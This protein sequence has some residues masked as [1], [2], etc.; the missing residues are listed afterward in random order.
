MRTKLVVALLIVL[1]AATGNLQRPPQTEQIKLFI[2]H[3]VKQRQW[4]IYASESQWKS[5]VNSSGAPTVASLEFEA[6]H[7]NAVDLTHQDEAGDWIVYDQYELGRTGELQQDQREIRILPGDR[8]VKEVYL[9]RD[10]IAHKQN[11]NTQSLSTGQKLTNVEDWLP[12]VPV[13]SRLKDFPFA[14]LIG[15]DRSRI[16]AKGKI[17]DASKEP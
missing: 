6:G 8:L 2:L 11:S 14:P 13:I 4:C 3:D 17:C 5:D 16:L 1:P 9:I 12:D 7:L 10:G 15:V